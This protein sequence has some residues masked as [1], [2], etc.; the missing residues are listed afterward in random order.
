ML[1]ATKSVP[2]RTH[3]IVDKPA[4]Q[5]LVEESVSERNRDI[6]IVISRQDS[7]SKIILTVHE[8]EDR[9]KARAAQKKAK[10]SN[11]K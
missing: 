7:L 10:L 6:M 1:P 4:L 5:Y 8:L 9:L 11:R 2:E 3:S